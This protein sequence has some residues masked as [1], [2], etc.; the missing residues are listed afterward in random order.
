MDSINFKKQSLGKSKGRWFLSINLLSLK[1]GFFMTSNYL[2]LFAITL[3]SSLFASSLP[4]NS[5]Y[6]T[7]SII[8]SHTLQ[9]S[10]TI[11]LIASGYGDALKIIKKVVVRNNGGLTITFT[12]PVE[13]LSGSVVVNSPTGSIEYLVKD[14]SLGKKS[15]TWGQG[16]KK[17]SKKQLLRIDT[18]NLSGQKYGTFL[19]APQQGTLANPAPYQGPRV[20][21]FAKPVTDSAVTAASYGGLLNPL[22]TPSASAVV[23]PAVV[24]GASAIAILG[25]IIVT[26]I[27]IGAASNGSGSAS[28]N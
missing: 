14:A 2:K 13:G 9:S 19:R 15:I 20:L 16:S 17:F 21:G 18:S 6:S 25:G 8:P 24:A 5:Q 27:A 7:S 28:S 3:S 12:E 1:K 11:N 22:A 23:A 26:G 10:S 4:V